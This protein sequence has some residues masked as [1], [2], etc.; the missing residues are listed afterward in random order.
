[1]LLQY[2]GKLKIQISVDIQPIWKK[3]QQIAFNRLTVIRPQ[4]LI[5]SLLKNGMSCPILIANKIF[6]VTVL[7]VIYF[8][9][10][11]VAPEIRHSR[12]HCSVCQ[13]STWYSATRTRFLKKFVWRRTKQ[14]GLQTHFLRNAVQ[15]VVLISCYKRCGTQAQFTG[16]QKFEFLI[17]QGSVATRLRWGG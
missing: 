7:L 6:H 9:S 8:C 11:F 16:G 13:Q 17:S 10:Q 12:R 15:S 2:L 14:R 5:F 1:M 3:M 4:I